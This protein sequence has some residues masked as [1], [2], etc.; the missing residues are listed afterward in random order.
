[1]DLIIEHKRAWARQSRYDW[2]RFS[3]RIGVG[4]GRFADRLARARLLF[5]RR[6]DVTSNWLA[7]ALV[8]CLFPVMFLPSQAHA[9]GPPPDDR[10]T[11]EPV[12]P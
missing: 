8:L 7:L 2:T 12:K 10:V 6:R 5:L 4:P 9:G 1:M 3:Q 11:V